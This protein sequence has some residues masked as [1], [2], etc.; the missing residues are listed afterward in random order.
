MATMQIFI[1][2]NL[3]VC[4][5][6]VLNTQNKCWVFNVFVKFNI[7]KNPLYHRQNFV[8]ISFKSPVQ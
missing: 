2:A 3:H 7:F 4:E 6:N 1:S 5:T 8:K